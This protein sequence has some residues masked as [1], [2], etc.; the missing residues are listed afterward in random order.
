M[1]IGIGT[2][3]EETSNFKDLTLE[4]NLNFLIKIFTKKELDYCFSKNNTYISLAG[5]F[6]SKEAVFKALCSIGI[7]GINFNEIEIINDKNGVPHASI[8]KI[9]P[10]DI[11][12][13]VSL[14][15]CEDKTVGFAIVEKIT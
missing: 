8:L 3:I 12:I 9:I 5:R 4:N 2:D 11:N 14:S 10:Y 15:H 6:V 13:H 7:N 1:N